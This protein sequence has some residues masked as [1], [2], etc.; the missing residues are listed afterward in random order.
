MFAFKRKDATVGVWIVVPV[1]GGDHMA[2]IGYPT[3]VGF[4]ARLA[5]QWEDQ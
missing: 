5:H 4:T 3:A 2:A 1:Q